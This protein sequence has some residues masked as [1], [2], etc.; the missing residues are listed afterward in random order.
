[1]QRGSDSGDGCLAA[2]PL[3]AAVAILL[4]R[5]LP[6]RF[7]YV[8]NDLGIVS[9]ATLARYPAQQEIFWF[10]FALGAGTVLTWLF[11]RAFRRAGATLAGVIR[12]EALGAAA[13]LA[14]LWLPG[15][16]AALV[17]AAAV[18]A[19][20]WIGFSG[21]TPLPGPPSPEPFP[22]SAPRRPRVA[23]AWI[24]AA[25]GLALLLCP[26]VWAG[27]WRVAT[28][29]PDG[30]LAFDN[31]TFL[32]E[33]G[34]HLAWTNA[35]WHGGFQGRDFFCLYGPLYDLSIAGLWALLGRS[36]AAYML[37][38]SLARAMGWTALF[39]LGGA[40]FRRPLLVLALPFLLPWVKLR[41]GL[42]LLGIL[43][44]VLW[45]R[46]RKPVWSA[47]AGLTGGVAILY[48]QEYGAAFA[49]VAAFAFLV[50]RQARAA[51]AFGLAFAAA[52]A[53]LLIW[54]AANDALRPMLRD[55]VQY[56]RYMMAG[57]AKMIF[58]PLASSVPLSI[59]ELGSEA[60]LQLR[61]SYAVPA[62][63][64]GALL[65]ALPVS[66][67]DPRRPIA[68][69]RGMARGLAR[70]PARF[71]VVLIAIFGLLSFRVALGRSSLPRT[72]A[73]LPPAVLLLGVA[74]D[75]V[76]DL[77]RQGP[78]RRALAAWR[79]AA[80]ALFVGLGGFLE[81]ARPATLVVKTVKD[82]HVLAT[83]RY[84]PV[85]NRH[86]LRVTRWVQL[87]TEPGEPVLFLPDDGAYYYLTDRPSP[88][89]FVMGHQ[90]VTDAHRREVL[91]DLRESPP[92]FIVWDHDAYR[93]DDLPED[94]VFGRP[95]LDWIEAGYRTET[96]IGGVEILRRI[97]PGG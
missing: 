73:V 7:E 45:L 6:I 34:Q 82:L 42:A 80:L 27:V 46:G 16:A 21:P 63:S 86:V 92:R 96:R 38:W 11:A 49:V 85:G 17:C 84:Q 59:T 47:L 41:I 28:G 36:I 2:L 48:S 32:G 15:T 23:A 58:P 12:C 87:N 30:R 4:A 51:L 26:G 60:S 5:W 95:L 62:V 14:V 52:V 25:I 97:G 91:S 93:V 94:L 66:A 90:I 72:L 81:P 64:L 57:Y 67:L 40:I 69:L 33:T 10:V 13:L 3:A 79:T 31:F 74:L 35:I 83:G 1:M 20:G 53:P 71:S 54:F 70:D 68:S 39:L 18:G 76:L 43:F 75:G 8:P 29:I 37:H 24:A 61:L 77:W 78:G 22:A 55:L 88:I 65:L 56:P 19:A 50:A 89:R 44:L 9:L